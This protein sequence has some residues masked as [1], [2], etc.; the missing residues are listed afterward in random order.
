G[1]CGRRAAWSALRERRNRSASFFSENRIHDPTAA[2]VWPVAATVTQQISVRATGF[3][4]GVGQD[5]E[6]GGVQQSGRHDAFVVRGLGEL[7]EGR[8]LPRQQ[9]RFEKG[10]GSD[11][12]GT[13][14]VAE[15]VTP[16]P[17]LFL[18]L[19]LSVSRRL[20][21]RQRG[22]D[23]FDHFVEVRGGHLRCREAR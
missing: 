22:S 23:D 11:R 3:F 18:L 19:P 8:I 10:L 12:E 16:I 2:N 15:Q 13:K 20:R 5:G 1:N 7:D 17:L 9:R 21:I 6:T 4:E 14:D